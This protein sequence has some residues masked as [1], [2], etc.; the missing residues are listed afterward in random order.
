MCAWVIQIAVARHP[1]AASSA[2]M[3]SDS[4]PGSIT[5]ASPAP[6]SATSQQFCANCPLG[7]P[8]TTASD[9]DAV[10]PLGQVLLHRD[11]GG[12][13]V[14]HGGGHLAGELDPEV[15]GG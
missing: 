15:A 9:T 11:G 4:S 14:A 13:R 1:R 10:L 5:A 12:G 6:G 2:R 7:I 8:T 3:R